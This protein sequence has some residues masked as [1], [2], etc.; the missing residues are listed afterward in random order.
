MNTCLDIHNLV[1]VDRLSCVIELGGK[2]LRIHL[3]FSYAN[4]VLNAGP[5]NQTSD[6]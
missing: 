1:L 5:Y 3:V 2:M 4:R 6:G